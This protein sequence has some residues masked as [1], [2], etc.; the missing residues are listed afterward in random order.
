MH[1]SSKRMWFLIVGGVVL[2]LAIVGFFASHHFGW[3]NA[4]AKKQAATPIQTPS[5]AATA[6]ANA[7]MWDVMAALAKFDLNGPGIPPE[8]TPA[9]LIQTLGAD[10]DKLLAS[11]QTQIVLGPYDGSMAEIPQIFEGRMAN[12]LDRARLL[13]TLRGLT[14]IAA[15]KPATTQDEVFKIIALSRYGDAQQKEDVQGA[16]DN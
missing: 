1:T 12:S 14:W 11:V 15:N 5:V 8:E 6:T 4:P 13:R 9:E 3:G 7:R 2:A 10:R 16:V